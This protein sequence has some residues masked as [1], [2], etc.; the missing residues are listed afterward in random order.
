MTR[1]GPAGGE[2]RALFPTLIYDAALG[3]RGMRALNRDLAAEARQIEAGDEAGQAW[4][5]E[6]YPGGYTS[7][8]SLDQL[9]RMAPSVMRL[10]RYLTRHA[11]R[12]AES[13]H[14][15]LRGRSLVM[16]DCWVSIMGEGCG[17][18]GHLHPLAVISGTY[19]AEAPRGTSG[20][21]FED[22]RLASFMAAPPRRADAPEAM[23]PHVLLPAREGRLYLFESWLRHEVPPNPVEDERI[24]FSF[25]FVWE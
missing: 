19:Y 20:L 15:D 18:P 21:R 16:S 12:F 13:L 1:P 11:L 23:R 22:P 24:S 25:N 3:A 2:P 9:Q 8:G 7:Y 14:W 5:A 10:E 6:R 17:H 4:S